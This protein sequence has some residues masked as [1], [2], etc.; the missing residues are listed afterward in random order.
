MLPQNHTLTHRTVQSCGD[1]DV[2]VRLERQTLA[3]L[4]LGVES[5]EAA[6]A[7]GRVVIDGDREAIN[8]LFG[9]LDSFP[10]MFNVVTPIST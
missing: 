2:T 3:D 7:D 6:I 10:F 1:A 9:M 8:G 4:V 5:I